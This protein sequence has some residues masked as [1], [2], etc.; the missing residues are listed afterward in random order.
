MHVSTEK[1]G[2]GALVFKRTGEILWQNRII[3][4]TN[5]SAFTGKNLTILF[6]NGTGKT[7]MIDGSSNP[8]SVLDARV[9][10]TGTLVRE[11]WP[12]GA[13][14]EVTFLYSACGCP[15]KVMARRTGERTARTKD[16]PVIF[17]DDSAVVQVIARLMG[18]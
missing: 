14:R 9:R 6:D 17:P 18:W 1:P 10:E 4:S 3:P 12:D 13:E 2:I 7:W 8:A 15:V 5:A 16:M 11:A